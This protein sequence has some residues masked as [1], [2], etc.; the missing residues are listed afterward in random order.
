LYTYWS[1]ISR[2]S[3]SAFDFCSIF[4]HAPQV[5]QTAEESKDTEID[6]TYI[7]YETRAQALSKIGGDEW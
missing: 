6:N 2:T 1:L 3:K 4:S 5:L 7:V